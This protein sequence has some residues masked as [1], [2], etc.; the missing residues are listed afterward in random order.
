MGVK[1]MFLASRRPQTL[2]RFEQALDIVTVFSI[3]NI[4]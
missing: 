1:E 4:Q 2:V 3:V